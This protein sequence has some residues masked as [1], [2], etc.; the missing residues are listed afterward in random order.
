MGLTENLLK[1]LHNPWFWIC[2]TFPMQ[3]LRYLLDL[4]H[5]TWPMVIKW[6]FRDPNI[7]LFVCT[8]ELYE[9]DSNPK[10][11][12]RNKKKNNNRFWC[13]KS[14]SVNKQ[15]E[16]QWSGVA[17][18]GGGLASSLFSLTRCY[19][20]LCVLSVLLHETHHMNALFPTVG[21]F[22]PYVPHC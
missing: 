10:F 13:I 8:F 11:G 14:T 5:Q 20:S 21:G 7:S 6:R 19:T 17:A 9:F 3:I 16:E 18:D 1:Q 15:A 2:V 22:M 12:H 4:S